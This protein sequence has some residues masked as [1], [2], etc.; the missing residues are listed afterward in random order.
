[1]R[2]TSSNSLVLS[3]LVMLSIL[4]TPVQADPEETTSLAEGSGYAELDQVVR[5]YL[6]KEAACATNVSDRRIERGFNMGFR[7]GEPHKSGDARRT[8]KRFCRKRGTTPTCGNLTKTP[9]LLR[10]GV[11]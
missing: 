11:L 6:A 3:L 9:R 1:M 5:A 7:S 2:F 10:G 8:P 4:I